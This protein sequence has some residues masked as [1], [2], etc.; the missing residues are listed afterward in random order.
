MKRVYII[1]EGQTEEEFVN[2]TLYDYFLKNK[3]YDVRPI[4]IQ[5][6]KAHKGGFVNYNHLKNDVIK[7]LKSQKDII[8]TTLVDFFRI[9]DNIPNYHNAMLLSTS[10]MKAE[11]LEKSMYNDIKNERFFPYIQVHEFETLLFS[12]IDGFKAYWS[13]KP[14]VLEQINDIMTEYPNPEDINLNPHSSPSNR[15]LRIIDEY[16]KIL[17]GNLIAIEIGIDTILEK[18]PRFKTWV[19]SIISKVNDN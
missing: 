4:K 2:T 5:T 3:I 18:C 19:D 17:Y 9:P 11:N 6:S 15:L 7:L 8:V 13:S 1:V 10:Y 14:R 12:S 16:D